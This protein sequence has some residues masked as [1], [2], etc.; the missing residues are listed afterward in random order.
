MGNVRIWILGAGLAISFAAFGD[1]RVS[2]NAS[3]EPLKVDLADLEKGGDPPG[4]HVQIGEHIAIHQ[5]IVYSTDA[6]D[7]MDGV[8]PRDPRRSV[9]DVYYPIIFQPSMTSPSDCR[10]NPTNMFP[11]SQNGNGNLLRSFASL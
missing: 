8:D 6:N 4:N 9:D 7:L 2:R 1:L 3:K 10:L 5:A 11:K